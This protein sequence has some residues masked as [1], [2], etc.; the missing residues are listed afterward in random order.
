MLILNA[1][2][3]MSRAVGP[4][5][6]ISFI[7]ACGGGG[8][9]SGIPPA[10]SPGSLPTST[11]TPAASSAPIPASVSGSIMDDASQ[12]I[13]GASVSLAPFQTPPPSGAPEP[14]MAP[15]V[16][17]TTTNAS[18]AYSFSNV[19][20]GTYLLSVTP[21]DTAVLYQATALSFP[22]PDPA[23]S[24]MGAYTNTH[25]ALHEKI[26]LASGSNAL[27][28]DQ[29]LRLTDNEVVCAQDFEFDRKQAGLSTPAVDSAA[30]QVV[31]I[32]DAYIAANGTQDPGDPYVGV[33]AM[34][35]GDYHT[36][37][38]C[39]GVV[40]PLPAQLAGANY[41]FVGLSTSNAGVYGPASGG[42]PV[43]YP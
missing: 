11:P 34:Q 24:G 40:N 32:A 36:G 10:G 22:T 7:T 30:L 16:A 23:N 37:S 20:A 42:S 1:R 28:I 31:R 6:L 19:P 2:S 39:V 21:Q 26:A 8:S 33:G 9:P 27:G 12:P 25:A 17:T 3:I 43:I 35:G 14:T 41:A 15:A 29:V 18:G 38:G 13:S 4:L 5:V